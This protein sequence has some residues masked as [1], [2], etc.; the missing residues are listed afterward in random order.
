MA[1]V[2]ES[3]YSLHVNTTLGIAPPLSVVR[4][5]IITR[6][7]VTVSAIL[8]AASKNVIGTMETA[9]VLLEEHCMQLVSTGPILMIGASTVIKI[10][11]AQ[12]TWLEMVT[13]MNSV[14]PKIVFST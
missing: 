14:I 7:S 2:I 13:A 8:V 11:S 12:I 4:H 10:T 9:T 5:V 1:T 3:V 6:G